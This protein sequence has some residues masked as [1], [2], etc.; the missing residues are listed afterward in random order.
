MHSAQRTRW[1]MIP[2]LL[3][4]LAV[5][6]PGNGQDR[7]RQDGRGRNGLAPRL[8]AAVAAGDAEAI[9]AILAEANPAVE[10]EAR[11]LMP[12]LQ[13]PNGKV[14]EYAALALTRIGSAEAAGAVIARVRTA[15]S[16]SERENFLFALRSAGNPAGAP[17]F[18]SVLQDPE[19]ENLH[20]LAVEVL[21]AMG[22][23]RIVNSVESVLGSN[24]TERTRRNLLRLVG[25]IHNPEATEYISAAL[26]KSGDTGLQSALALALAKIG[27]RESIEALTGHFDGGDET[28][29][30]IVARALSYT[31]RDEA[32]PLLVGFL[33]ANKPE[34]LLVGAARALRNFERPEL[35]DQI[36]RLAATPLPALVRQELA[37]S[38]GSIAMKLNAARPAGARQE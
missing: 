13:H 8:E 25:G 31:N 38:R 30:A 17:A 11:Q 3:L 7:T 20:S 36:D 16:S 24:P 22:T 37:A 35:L 18:F 34:A 12:L 2:G 33:G 19:A 26:A 10:N 1:K 14:A 6:I 28:R 4:A 27:T 9:A 23:A 29:Q 32:L 15:A 21:S 5:A